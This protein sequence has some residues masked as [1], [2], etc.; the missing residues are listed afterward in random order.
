MAAFSLTP[1]IISSSWTHSWHH[2]ALKLRK[3]QRPQLN[4]TYSVVTCSFSTLI[5]YVGSYSGGLNTIQALE[6]VVLPLA[7]A[8]LKS[9]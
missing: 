1:S 4:C 8:G 5:E 6:I 7:C 2:Q 9:P 3:P